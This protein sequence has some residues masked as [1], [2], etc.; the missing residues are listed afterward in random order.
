MAPLAN[1]TPMK[2]GSASLPFFG[3]KCEIRDSSTGK[4]LEGAGSGTLTLTGHWPGISRTVLGDHQKY[5]KTYFADYEGIYSTGDGCIRDKEGY[6]S[7]TGRMDDVLKKAGHRIGTAEVYAINF[8]F[9]FFSSKMILSHASHL[10][11][12]YLFNIR[13]SRL[14]YIPLRLLKLL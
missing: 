5:W 4:P 14:Y 7:I 2:P 12:L 3:I 6:I 8:F 9:V 1:V 11:A 10:G 13:S